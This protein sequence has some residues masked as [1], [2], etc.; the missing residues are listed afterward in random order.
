MFRSRH[1]AIRGALIAAAIATPGVAAQSA[2][3]YVDV[4]S[5]TSHT[6]LLEE[7]GA[8]RPCAKVNVVIARGTDEQADISPG[9][10]G[11]FWDGWNYKSGPKS[12][13]G[14]WNRI[15]KELFQPTEGS[16]A[17][18][19]PND[20][21]RTDVSYPAST[22]LLTSVPSGTV[23]LMNYLTSV[24]NRCGTYT[25]FVLLGFSQGALVVNNAV[26]VPSG[27]ISWVSGTQALT[28]QVIN[29]I[30]AIG[31]IADTGFSDAF[32]PNAGLPSIH[33]GAT[34]ATGY[35]AG[36]VPDTEHAMNDGNFDPQFW[37]LSPRHLDAYPV[38][39][40]AEGPPGAVVDGSLSESVKFK[41]RSYC[42]ARDWACQN[43]NPQN[44]FQVHTDTAYH[45][46]SKK[47]LA[48]WAIER[49]RGLF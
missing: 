1:T 43:S 2:S 41:I 11:Y 20:V 12:P 34:I 5:L 35:A 42:I 17:Y 13:Y 31:T 48:I 45:Q 28:S 47:N 30:V 9:L 33:L 18:T 19:S 29:Q 21:L 46:A 27:R 23:R 49:I 32:N 36:T 24:N 26:S 44:S 14:T 16:P 15:A 37:G 3:A 8:I 22:S 4:N 10:D 38:R 6:T 40:A 25:K 39:I 7:Q